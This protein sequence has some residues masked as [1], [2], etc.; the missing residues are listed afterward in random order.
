MKYI[1]I[2]S[3]LFIFV[4]LPAQSSNKIFTTD[5]DNFWIAYDSIQQTNDHAKKIDFINKLYI[6]KGTKGLK[7]FMIARNYSDSIYVDLIQKYPKFWNSIRPNTL[8]IKN[9]TAEL[10]QSINRFQ[11]LYPD[12]KEAEMYFTI[13]G[14][15]SAGTVSGNMVLVGAELATGNSSN[16]VSEFK[17]NWIKN[18][19]AQQSLD[20]I[21]S[22]NIHEYVHTQQ[23][24]NNSKLLLHQTIREGS[25]DFITE[26]IIGSPL[27]TAYISYGKAHFP[28]LKEQ[29][30]AEMFSNYYAN[31]LYNGGN[32]PE[33]A[34]LGY[35]IGYEICKA[36]Y[37]QA[38]DKKQAIKDI[39]ELDY[40]DEKAVEDFLRKSK[41]YK[42]GFTK[43]K[44]IDAYAKKQ[45][46]IVSIAPFDNGDRA[47]N[48]ET[49]EFRILFSKEMNPSNYSFRNSKK[50][51]EYNPKITKVK[52]L[53]KDG[54]TFV[55]ELAL[56]PNQEYELIIGNGFSS[57]DGYPLNQDNYTVQFKTK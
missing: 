37:K 40:S 41:F 55:I 11:Q 9:K 54:K 29:F 34:D 8:S 18:I 15:R 19:F 13:G 25:C 14:Q 50:G 20:N 32:N 49:K 42:E 45:P 43:K 2:I 7:T 47:V 22:L 24:P 4:E 57:M 39:I 36:Y 3:F 27:E 12:L 46:Y 56:Q 5:I 52:G 48:P 28:T 10:Q 30:K 38:K 16:D 51:K 21:V 53:E 23:K 35:F 44:L 33:K 17:N 26:L 31:W 1:F 6:N